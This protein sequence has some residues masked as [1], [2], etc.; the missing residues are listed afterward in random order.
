M[1]RS[2]KELDDAWDLDVA[3]HH[4]DDLYVMQDQLTVLTRQH[5]EY[6][7][8]WMRLGEDID[9]LFADIMVPGES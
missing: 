1:E 3:T 8:E 4:L 6:G 7:K 5:D 9:V 2:Q